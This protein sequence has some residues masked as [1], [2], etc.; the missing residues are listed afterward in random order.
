[1]AFQATSEAWKRATYAFAVEIF[2]PTHETFLF[3]TLS[4]EYEEYAKANGKP[5]SVE[6]RAFAGL[7]S[8][9]IK[10]GLIVR[11]DEIGYRSNGQIGN[12]YRR[13]A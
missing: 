2:L 13:V 1:M 7:Q 8:K 11:T 5:I 9:L 6:K 12:F 3:E 4:Q 10:A